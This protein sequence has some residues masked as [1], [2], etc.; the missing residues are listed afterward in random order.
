M[1][2]K[3]TDSKKNIDTL[4]WDLQQTLNRSEE[5]YGKLKTNKEIMLQFQDCLTTTSRKGG[6]QKEYQQRL[7][8]IKRKKAI[9][10]MVFQSS[11]YTLYIVCI[12]MIFKRIFFR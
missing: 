10:R 5:I 6:V 3:V 12:M 2:S 8:I 7:S 4:K 11:I 9:S 1:K